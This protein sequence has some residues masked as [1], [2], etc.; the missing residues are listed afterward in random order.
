[1]GVALQHRRQGRPAASEP[2]PW[3]A[4]SEDNARR[5]AA[6]F[7]ALDAEGHFDRVLIPRLR[8]PPASQEQSGGDEPMDR[9]E[10][11]RCL[12]KVIAYIACGKPELAR[13][14][15]EQLIA[16]WRA[17]GVIDDN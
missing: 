17:L 15:A 6:T 13:P 12:A 3:D 5:E 4:A 1:M 7:L 11:A 9:K 14:W 8:L 10:S 16:W 2:R